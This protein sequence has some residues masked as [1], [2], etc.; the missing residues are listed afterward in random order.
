LRFSLAV[1]FSSHVQQVHLTKENP[2][3]TKSQQQ[4]YEIKCC[5]HLAK[6]HST[7]TTLD[8]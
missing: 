4:Q 6:C 5:C 1:T 3:A 8:C 2:T 7:A